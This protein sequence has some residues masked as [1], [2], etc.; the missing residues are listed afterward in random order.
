MY[1]AF[2][3]DEETFNT[4]SLAMAELL[5]SRG[6]ELEFLLDEGGGNIEDG[7]IYG[8]PGVMTCG[9]H[10]AEKGY[11]DLTVRARGQGGHSSNPFG[12]S[13]LQRLAQAIAAICATAQA[14]EMPAALPAMCCPR[15]WRPT[16][17]SASFPVTLFPTLTGAA[18][19]R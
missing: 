19:K 11:A 7:A 5:E 13:S 12:G 9:I 10:L 6:V 2:G 1:L 15:I 14:A 18:G 3:E 16:S 17:T 4:G 8:A